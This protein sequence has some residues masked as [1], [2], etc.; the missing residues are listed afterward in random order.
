MLCLTCVSELHQ[1]SVVFAV[2]INMMDDS[3]QFLVTPLHQKDPYRHCDTGEREIN[4]IFHITF[5]VFNEFV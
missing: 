2:L 1:R 5:S 4:E 3:T